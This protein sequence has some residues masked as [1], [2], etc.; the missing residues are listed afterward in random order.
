MTTARQGVRTRRLALITVLGVALSGAA[1]AWDPP[2]TQSAAQRVAALQSASSLVPRADTL[3]P[4]RNARCADY[5]RAA[6]DDYGV[7]RRFPEC[8]VPN[9]GRWQSNFDAHYGWCMANRQAHADWIQAEARARNDH[10]VKCGVR[11]QF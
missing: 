11:K 4:E 6:V 7:M 1:M 8:L 5:A 3:P 10:L 2:A 9:D